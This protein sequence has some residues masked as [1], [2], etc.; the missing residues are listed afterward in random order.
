[1][2]EDTPYK[3]NLCGYNNKQKI[4]YCKNIARYIKDIS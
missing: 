4:F 1:M 2:K 3:Q